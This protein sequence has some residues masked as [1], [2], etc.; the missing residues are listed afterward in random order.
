MPQIGDG[1]A[2]KI[3][4][5]F[6]LFLALAGCTKDPIKTESSNNADVPVDLLF[7]HDGC[8]VYRFKDGGYNIYYTK[9]QQSSQTAWNTAQMVGKTVIIT[10]HQ[11]STEIE[12]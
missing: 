4:A 12:R 8:K 9:C 7:E 10:P 11:V 1:V 2:M 3:V 6:T 5:L